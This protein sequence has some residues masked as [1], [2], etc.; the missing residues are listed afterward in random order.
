MKRAQG[1]REVLL[2][3][4]DEQVLRIALDPRTDAAR[5]LMQLLGGGLE[6]V[7]PRGLPAGLG[8][9]VN[10]EFLYDDELEW[11]DAATR[12]V[13]RE[14]VE[15]YGRACVVRERGPSLVS[16]TRVDLA[17]LA[18]VLAMPLPRRA[19]RPSARLLAQLR[20]SRTEDA[21]EHSHE[22]SMQESPCQ[23]QLDFEFEPPDDIPF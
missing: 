1:A 5:A 14:G 22:S 16:L 18:R 6:R 11:N 2:L 4:D 9:Y 20:R 13:R 21:R 7:T 17:L 15:I 19:R 10:D 23:R 3:T 12:L 8:L